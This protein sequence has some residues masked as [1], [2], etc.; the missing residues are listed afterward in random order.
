M[1]NQIRVLLPVI[2]IAAAILLAGCSMSTDTHTFYSYT[3]RPTTLS[4]V[5]NTTKE[6]LWTMDIPVGKKL[7]VDFDGNQQ[8]NEVFKNRVTPATR[9]KWKLLDHEESRESLFINQGE[10][11]LDLPGRPIMMQVSYREAPEY[12]EEY[13]PV[14]PPADISIEQ[15]AD[16]ETG[17]EISDDTADDMEFDQTIEDEPAVTDEY[18]DDHMDVMDDELEDEVEDEITP[19]DK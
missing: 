11:T 3:Y 18:M 14:T 12:P 1:A 15:P 6:T 10:G 16:T 9:M 13:L 8:F 5:D 19:M 2:I 7:V 17:Q 4:L